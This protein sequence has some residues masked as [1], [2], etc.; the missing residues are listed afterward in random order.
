MGPLYFSGL[1]LWKRPISRWGG[2]T[3]PIGGAHVE[4]D[5]VNGKIYEVRE[6]AF[7]G[8]GQLVQTFAGLPHGTFVYH[9]PDQLNYQK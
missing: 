6:Y 5:V 4:A 3:A 8:N 1:Q 2:S 9:H 7:N